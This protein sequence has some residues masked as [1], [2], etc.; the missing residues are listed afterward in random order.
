MIS[1]T[2][3]VLA[4]RVEASREFLLIVTDSG[5]YRVPWAECSPILANATEEERARLA[6]SPSGYG[7]HWPL[8]DEDLTV[9]GLVGRG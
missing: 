3:V 7:I 5:E 8:L 9:K 1:A 6:V 2:K 4:T